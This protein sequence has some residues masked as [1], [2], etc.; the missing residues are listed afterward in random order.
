M[1]TMTIKGTEIMEM[2]KTLSR[3]GELTVLDLQNIARAGD[4]YAKELDRKALRGAG[5]G[6]GSRV[7]FTSRDGKTCVGTIVKMNAKSVRVDAPAP[8]FRSWLVPPSM[9]RPA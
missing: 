7:E 8:D 4:F 3:A 9:L 1:A 2:L 6:V 5:F